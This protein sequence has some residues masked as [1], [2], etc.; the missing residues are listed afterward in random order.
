MKKPAYIKIATN[1]R[2][3][4]LEKD[5]VHK[6]VPCPKEYA[7]LYE[8]DV[9]VY[10]AERKEPVRLMS[11]EYSETTKPK[12]DTTL[13]AK[14]QKKLSELEIEDTIIINDYLDEIYGKHDYFTRR[15][16]DVL[17]SKTRKE[18]K[19]KT[20]KVIKGNLTRLT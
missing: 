12:K 15:S 6:V 18:L 2:D 17:M 20:F 19:P 16:F 5:T 1:L 4:G 11:C 8:D 3:F 7:E 13:T 9:W 10:S 14:L